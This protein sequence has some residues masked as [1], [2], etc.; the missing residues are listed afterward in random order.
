MN[1]L[2]DNQRQAEMQFQQKIDDKLAEQDRLY[3]LRIGGNSLNV[4]DPNNDPSMSGFHVMVAGHI[5]SG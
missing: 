4:K 1:E 2:D 3:Q 5:E